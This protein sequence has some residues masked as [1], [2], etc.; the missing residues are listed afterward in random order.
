MTHTVD[1][2][3]H[4][5]LT[6]CCGSGSYIH[7][8]ARVMDATRRQFKRRL[9]RV[10]Y[11]KIVALLVASLSDIYKMCCSGGSCGTRGQS[12]GHAPG[13]TPP[14]TVDFV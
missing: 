3:M 10:F 8:R 9:V 14:C 7:F 11:V 6:C 1:A 2:K 5:L 12:R 13:P 4:V